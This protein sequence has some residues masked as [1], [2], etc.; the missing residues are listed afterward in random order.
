MSVRAY[1]YTQHIN[2]GR[3]LLEHSDPIIHENYLSIY[4]LRQH[5]PILK[6][7]ASLYMILQKY[8]KP[9]LFWVPAMGPILTVVI[10]GVFTFLVNGPEHGIQI[11]RIHIFSIFSYI[12]VLEITFSLIYMWHLI[13]G[14]SL[15]QRNQSS[16]HTLVK[17]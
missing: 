10:S 3:H 8:K 9:K 11:V 5:G 17:L 12:Y 13:L 4:N 14:G 15:G 1:E 7:H 2:S 6:I 16:F